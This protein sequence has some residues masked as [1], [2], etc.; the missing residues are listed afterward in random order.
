MAR[1]FWWR[2]RGW[3]HE[4]AGWTL[5]FAVAFP[6]AL[7]TIPFSA[8][9]PVWLAIAAEI[10][11]LA[12]ILASAV[13][14]WYAKRH[15]WLYAAPIGF[16]TGFSLPLALQEG[17]SAQVQLVFNIAVP[18]LVIGMLGLTVVAFVFMGRGL[19]RLNRAQRDIVREIGEK[20][21]NE[22]LFRDDGE[23]ITVYASRGGLL[24]RALTIVAALALFVG[25]GL[26][27]L[28][29]VPNV[30]WRI[31]IAVFIGFLLCFGGLSTLLTLIRTLMIGPTLIV[32]ADGIRDNC[33]M[34]VTGRGLLRWNETLEVE[35]FTFSPNAVITYRFLDINV[36]D[37]LTIN[38]RQPLWKRVLGIFANH[39]QSVGFRI[40]RPLLDR[41][42]GELISEI[43]HYI[44]THAPV[45]S[46]HK[47]VTDDEPEQS[48]ED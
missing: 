23:R 25:S 12:I 3:W 33:S 46:W 29:I 13:K 34:I 30:F 27:A 22:G 18:A 26:W 11:C 14:A 40:P 24:L 15:A 31:V 16:G 38:R 37:A 21:A 2:K 4:L 41:P 1:F 39:R 19:R 48:G 32:N 17:W 10:A 45:G 20:I 7:A 36:T 44:N 9:V 28:T 5:G 47:A 6:S 8:H 35:E 42:I 43:N